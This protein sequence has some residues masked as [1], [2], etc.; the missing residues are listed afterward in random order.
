MSHTVTMDDRPLIVVVDD[1]APEEEWLDARAEGI[2][3]SEIHDIAVG[4]R[5][6]WRTILDAKLNGSTFRG[7]RHTRKGHEAEP[8]ILAE[9]RDVA[10]VATLAPSTALF[11][12]PEHPLH[13]CTPDGLGTH[14]QLGD[15]GFEAKHH[16]EGHEKFEIPQ[17]H[18]DQVQWGMWI[19]GLS[20]WLY[21][22]KI[23]GVYGIR[24]TWIGRDDKRIAFLARQADAFIAWREAG[25]P[26]IDDIPD[27]VDDALADYA[28]GL[29]LA[30][31]GEAL[32][33]AARPVIENYARSSI[34]D[35]DVLRKAGS[36][37][38]VLYAPK[39]VEVLDETA[40]AEAEPE[41]YA[42]WVDARERAAA[43]EKA[44]LALYSK[45]KDGTPTFRV[46][47]NGETA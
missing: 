25:A 18:M 16:Q 38:S 9:A 46:T 30:G 26:E 44:A 42:E 2:T 19:L 31:Q 8:L 36:R 37:A 24:H 41:T 45:T 12:H 13:R 34:A 39:T 7:N 3:A 14:A 23:D 5:K 35:E 33:K 29:A 28:R 11:A 47:V 40:W 20:W 43:Q 22:V 1:G 32:K 6:A 10:G 27:E 15:F 21:A 17:D 4:S